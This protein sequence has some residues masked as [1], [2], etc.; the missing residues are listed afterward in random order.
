[1][2]LILMVI[3]VFN[4]HFQSNGFSNR[5]IPKSNCNSTF[6]ANQS[7]KFLGAKYNKYATLFNSIQV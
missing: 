6:E 3:G 4:L 2:V 1:M 5:F 7:L